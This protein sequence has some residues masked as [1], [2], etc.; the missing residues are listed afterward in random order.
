GVIS[1]SD[2]AAAGDINVVGNGKIFGLRYIHPLPA[3]DTYSH[4]LTL[5]VDYK[6]FKESTELQGADSFNTPIAYTPFYMGYDATLLGAE[7]TTQMTLGVTFS[8]RGLGNDEQEF[9]DKRFLAKPN[10]AYLR[11][12]LKHTE[13]FAGWELTGNLNGQ[14][15]SQ[16]LIANEQFFIG[17]VD[18]VRG[19]LEA[20][21]LGDNGLSGGLELR[22][23]SLAKYFGEQITDFRILAF[24]DAGRVGILEALPG[25]TES[26]TLKSAGLGLRV[27][28]LRGVSAN[29]DYA[30]AMRDAPPVERGDDLLHFRIAYDW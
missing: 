29:L 7:R 9:A 27:K 26:F 21:A 17:G 1:K 19:Y 5:G 16:P 4:S 24:Y 6:D 13:K 30:L 25:Q 11:A 3:V 18:S 28:T 14:I 22:T 10:F 8:V 23:P 15:A 20:N 12:D 2:V